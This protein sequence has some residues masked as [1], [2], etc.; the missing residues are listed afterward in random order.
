MIYTPMKEDF[1]EDSNIIIEFSVILIVLE[2]MEENCIFPSSVLFLFS[3]NSSSRTAHKMQGGQNIS[4][5]LAGIVLLII[6]MTF[7]TP[8]CSL[9]NFTRHNNIHHYHS[10]LDFFFFP[11]FPSSLSLS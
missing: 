11:L 7:S 1:C 10:Q 9:T 4:N 8:I 2:E 3:K 6:N 5:F